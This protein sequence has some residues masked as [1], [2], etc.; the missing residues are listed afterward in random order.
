MVPAAHYSTT[1]PK[2]ILADIMSTKMGIP[3]TRPLNSKRV[4]E[5]TGKRLI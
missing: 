2:A 1:R 4:H 5:V 3:A